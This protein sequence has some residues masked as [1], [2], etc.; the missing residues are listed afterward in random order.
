[1]NKFKVLNSLTG[2]VEELETESNLITWYMCGP[3]VYNDSHIGH[4]RNY[5]SNDIIRRILN[6]YGYNVYQTMNITDIDDKIINKAEE[7][8]GDKKHFSKIA[9]DYEKSF[10]EDM[11][12]LN[13]Q[14][15]DIVTRV[16]QYMP[17]II[18]FITDLVNK[19]YVYNP[20]NT[21]SVYFDY[22]K[23][24]E[25]YEDYFNIKANKP[26]SEDFIDEKKNVKDFVLWKQAK[27]NEP[28]WDSPWV[29]TRSVQ[30]C[31]AREMDA[32]DG[33]LNVLQCLQIFLAK[34]LQCILEE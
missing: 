18:N 23:Y 10:F 20:E 17:E 19:G 22:D 15:P 4:A 6:N 28:F 9:V 5:I 24:S 13:V 14:M 29:V 30:P 1:M 12:K 32:L 7:T 34:K 33:T 3:T 21:S 27:I 8:L 25:K 16:S 11:I 31:F 2:L 26:M